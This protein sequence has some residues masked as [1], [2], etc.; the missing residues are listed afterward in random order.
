MKLINQLHTL[1]HCCRCPLWIWP[2]SCSIP[3]SFFALFASPH[4]WHWHAFWLWSHLDLWLCYSWLLRKIPPPLRSCPEVLV[5]LSR[6]VVQGLV[7]N[8]CRVLLALG[9]C[10]LKLF[11]LWCPQILQDRFLLIQQNFHQW[12]LFLWP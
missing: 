2:N 11:L 1:I 8:R 3:Q 6:L 7:G 10:R 5:P 4:P 12:Q 9:K